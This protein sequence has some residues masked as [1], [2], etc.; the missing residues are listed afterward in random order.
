[1]SYAMPMA[2]VHQSTITGFTY[3]SPFP[4]HA[5][6]QEVGLTLNNSVHYTAGEA[7]DQA[8]AG[9]VPHFLAMS[10]T[11]PYAFFD[12]QQSL[13]SRVTLRF[14]PQAIA[15]SQYDTP[16]FI[17]LCAHKCTGFVDAAVC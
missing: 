7:D 17:T 11:L 5:P 9:V 14:T 4:H 6:L 15:G 2:F 8:V 10:Y 13:N 1:M 16:Y 3:Q 12:H